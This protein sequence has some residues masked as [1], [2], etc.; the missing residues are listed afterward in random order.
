MPNA[1]R[2]LRFLEREAR[3]V[4]NKYVHSSVASWRKVYSRNYCDKLEAPD[5]RSR[6]YVIAGVIRELLPRSSEIL[7]V[8]CG[9]GTTCALLDLPSYHGIDLAP[10]AIDACLKAF[11]HRAGG[12]EVAD[13]M[14][15]ELQKYDAVIFNEVL[16]YFPLRTLPEL[17]TKTLASLKGESSLL[18]V[19]M[20]ETLKSFLVW[21][22]L[23][24]LGW[25]IQ[26]VRVA[27][28]TLGSRWTVKVYRPLGESP[29]QPAW[30]RQ[31][32]TLLLAD[33]WSSQSAPV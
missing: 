29:K 8:G 21:R 1:S 5:Q 4:W 6:H 9:C 27:S 22:Q 7:D 26:D 11:P 2:R 24:A 28:R 10:E 19:S 31:L 3:N 18:V 20:S 15:Y 12:F 14:T 33:P 32:S 30:V 16:Y 25:P 13:F 17:L 23:D